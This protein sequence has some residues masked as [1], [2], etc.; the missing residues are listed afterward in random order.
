MGQE[1]DDRFEQ[2]VLTTGFINARIGLVEGQVREETR[3]L[4]PDPAREIVGRDHV[5]GTQHPSLP[6]KVVIR[7]LSANWSGAQWFARPVPCT[8]GP[9]A[10][11]GDPRE[12]C[13]GT[14]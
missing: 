6:R 11:H 12:K 7:I 10:E 3:D 4:G 9:D 1:L 14:S 5:G 8:M 13:E 2:E